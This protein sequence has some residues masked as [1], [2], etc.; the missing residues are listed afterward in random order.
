M[1]YWCYHYHIMYCQAALRRPANERL[2]TLGDAWL[3]LYMS[4][5]VMQAQVC[6]CIQLETFTYCIIC[7]SY[8]ALY[9]T[10]AIWGDSTL[11]S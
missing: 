1:Y 11:Q 2:E 4:L 9:F 6:D 8:A 5:V 7:I 10:T 3:K